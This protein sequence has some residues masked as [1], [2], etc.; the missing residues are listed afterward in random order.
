MKS[1]R[2]LPPPRKISKFM[3]F[4]L[5]LRLPDVFSRIKVLHLTIDCQDFS[6]LQHVNLPHSSLYLL[7]QLS[8]CFLVLVLAPLKYSGEPLLCF[9]HKCFFPTC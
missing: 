6:D 9:L 1:F 2:P 3:G 4:S 5:C 8:F 7:T